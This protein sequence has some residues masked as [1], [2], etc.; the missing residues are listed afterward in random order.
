V[1]LEFEF[2][3]VQVDEFVIV[4]NLGTTPQSRPDPE[5]SRALAHDLL[6]LMVDRASA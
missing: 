5:E 3:Y 6:A 1:P 4:F 2:T